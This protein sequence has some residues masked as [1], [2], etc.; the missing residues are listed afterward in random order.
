MIKR[1]TAAEME[2]VARERNTPCPCCKRL[3]LLKVI[4]AKYGISVPRVV[5]IVNGRK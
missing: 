4:A 3:P 1:L 5:N 2:A